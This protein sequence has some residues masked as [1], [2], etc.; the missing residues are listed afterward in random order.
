[1]K[2]LWE[3]SIQILELFRFK[4]ACSYY[5]CDEISMIVLLS[6][7]TDTQ[8]KSFVITSKF[9]IGPLRDTEC[10]LLTPN[11]LRLMLI[12]VCAQVQEVSGAT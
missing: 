10:P 8:I 12:S 3:I 5:V 4:Y 2:S 6:E 9:L 1:M 7:D 11:T